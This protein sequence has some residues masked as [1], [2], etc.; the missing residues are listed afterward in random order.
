MVTVDFNRLA[1]KPG[2]KI[3]DIGCGSGRHTSA[4]YRIRIDCESE[5]NHNLIL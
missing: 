4:A 5:A 1:V 3:L 2:Y